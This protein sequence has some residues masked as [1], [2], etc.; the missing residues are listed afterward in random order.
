MPL[1][2]TILP[3]KN[4]NDPFLKH[5]LQLLAVSAQQLGLGAT[6]EDVVYGLIPGV[7]ARSVM[8]PVS[9][10]RHV[11]ESALVE[12]GVRIKAKGGSV[13]TTDRHQCVVHYRY[14]GDDGEPVLD[15][16][17]V[18]LLFTDVS[19]MQIAR[20]AMEHA[21]APPVDFKKVRAE[22]VEIIEH[23]A[24]LPEPA[25]KAL[26]VQSRNPAF[27]VSE[28]SMR[29][30]RVKKDRALLLL[31]EAHAEQCARTAYTAQREMTYSTARV[32]YP[33]PAWSDLS[34]ARRVELIAVT[35]KVICGQTAP[36][37]LGAEYGPLF[38]GVVQQCLMHIVGAGALY[39]RERDAFSAV[40]AQIEDARGLT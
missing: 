17:H 34:D 12:I 27:P 33:T 20:E 36:F 6:V 18:R 13:V 37:A 14:R 21:D 3:P 1:L 31:A 32:A 30:A 8:L 35:T 11:Y 39:Q 10:H 9:K 2:E 5:K 24:E 4:E 40:R 26:L 25:R 19:F 23:D 28:L 15:T 7:A 29:Y 38:L 22:I 16:V